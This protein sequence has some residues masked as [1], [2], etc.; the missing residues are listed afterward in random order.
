MVRNPFEWKTKEPGTLAKRR[1]VLRN[2]DRILLCGM[3]VLGVATLIYA[4]Q[5]AHLDIFPTL[6]C[7][8]A[9]VGWGVISLF[10]CRKQ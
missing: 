2:V 10:V 4:W 7:A 8:L 1:A 6:I 9:L 5:N 3:T